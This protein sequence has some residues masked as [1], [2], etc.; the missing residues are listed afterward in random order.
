MS[1]VPYPSIDLGR[2]STI[3]PRPA[4]QYVAMTS[5][6]LKG[7]CISAQT[8]FDVRLSHPAVDAA[9]LQ[10]LLDH[11]KD[12]GADYAQLTH[13]GHT[14]ELR[15]LAPPE[16][17][18]VAPGV[19]DVSVALVGSRLSAV[20]S[21]STV[22]TP[23]ALQ[24]ALA[25]LWLGAEGPVGGLST[26]DGAEPDP[27]AVAAWPL[28]YSRESRLQ[29]AEAWRFDPMADGQI[30]GRR[31]SV[32]DVY[33]IELAHPLITQP[34]LDGLLYHYQRHQ[35]DVVRLA[36][37]GDVYDAHYLGEPA[38]RAWGPW[39]A[40][41]VRFVGTRLASGY[42]VQAMEDACDALL[43]TVFPEEEP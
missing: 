16:P 42:A 19:Y 39:R 28:S 24:E 8:V 4:Y 1:T 17:R 14:F 12:H 13:A 9:A 37:A 15:Y 36:Y 33:Q 10:L 25:G 41:S 23:E 3:T 22:T 18:L 5:G 32:L 31:D 6:R 20:P 34:Q 2:D 21:Y 26:T 43:A 38:V 7:R 30:I 40:A 29:P 27:D 35:R 11:Y